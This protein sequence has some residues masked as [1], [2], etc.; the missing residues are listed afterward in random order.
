MNLKEQ[1][2]SAT[3][4]YAKR[5]VIVHLTNLFISTKPTQELIEVISMS[6]AD[7]DYILC[8]TGLEACLVLGLDELAYVY[9]KR[10]L[11]SDSPE[12][13]VSASL[14]AA[15]WLLER[16][17]DLFE[18][19]LT[20]TGHMNESLSFRA[21][22][23]L[24]MATVQRADLL[25]SR[26]IMRCVALAPYPSKRV[27]TECLDLMLFA[28]NNHAIPVEFFDQFTSSDSWEVRDLAQRC[29]LKYCTPE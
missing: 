7:E 23:S 8:Y 20:Y 5:D 26:L 3:T 18:V 27:T 17:T 25:F 22:E 21:I 19:C 16:H 14:T 4:R 2:L 13:Q 1:Y 15:S 12:S 6:L 11:T 24:R 10:V 9:V 29:K 28:D